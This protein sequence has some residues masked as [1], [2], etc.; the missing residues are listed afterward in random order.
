MPSRMNVPG[1]SGSSAR[2][3][4]QTLAWDTPLAL[5]KQQGVAGC[6]HSSP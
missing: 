3:G 6:P 4:N 5:C 2:P 1:A